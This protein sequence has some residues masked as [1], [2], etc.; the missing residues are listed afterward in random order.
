MRNA[1]RTFL[2]AYARG[3]GAAACA[4]LATPT[5]TALE[6]QEQQPCARA[7]TDLEIANGAIEQIEVVATSA[8]VDLHSGQSL[9]ASQV[10]GEWRLSAVGCTPDHKP[11]DHPFNCE[12]EA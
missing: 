4:Q 9:F 7:I 3:D 2:A 5:V 12:L 10:D 11:A 8:K 1:A 6:D